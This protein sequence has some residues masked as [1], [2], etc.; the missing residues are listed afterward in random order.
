M[1]SRYDRKRLAPGVTSA[2]RVLL[3]RLAE[4]AGELIHAIAKTLRFGWTS[5][6]PEIITG[7]DNRQYVQRELGD[8]DEI[9]RRLKL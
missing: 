5:S 2:E 1:K 3:V 8:V 4:E 9:A 6:N 7:E